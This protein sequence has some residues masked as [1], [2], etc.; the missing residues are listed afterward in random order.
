MVHDGVGF[1]KFGPA[2]YSDVVNEELVPVAKVVRSP[3]TL[4]WPSHA[5]VML[6]VML[7]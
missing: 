1:V 5:V 4:G 2:R 3:T 7:W 6:A